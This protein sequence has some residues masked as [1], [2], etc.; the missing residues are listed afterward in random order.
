MSRRTT[1]SAAAL[2]LAG[3]ISLALPRPGS[4]QS[5]AARPGSASTML[6]LL[7]AAAPPAMRALKSSYRVRL[8]STWPQERG[9]GGCLNGG[10]EIVEG[11][12]VRTGDGEYGG[13]FARRTHLLFCGAHGRAPGASSE[14]CSLVLEGQGDV[15]MSG[16]VVTDDTSPSGRSARVVWSPTDSGRVAVTG[17]CAPAFKEAL[18]AMY[19]ATRHGIEFPLTTTGEG[20]RDERLETYAWRVELE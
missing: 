3:L 11:T 4:A 12:L 14:R 5:A 10:E 8:T 15:A 17:A 1:R 20:P 16:Q 13:T 6:A 19:R 2:T 9:P 18:A 7:P